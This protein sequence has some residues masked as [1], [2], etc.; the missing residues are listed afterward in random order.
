M[1]IQFSSYDT[2]N[3]ENVLNTTDIYI[4]LIDISTEKI[5]KI[6][7]ETYGSLKKSTIKS[8]KSSKRCYTCKPRGKV[9]KHIICNS[10]CGHFVFH[11]DMNHR[12]LI[13][14]T[15]IQHINT[16]YELN[17]QQLSLLFNAIN[18]FCKFWNINDYQ[19]SFHC[20]SWQTHEHLHIKMK[21]DKRIIERMRGDHFRK[22]K[23]DERYK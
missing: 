17:E 13:I 10:T 16:I 19:I 8:V 18:T 3:D 1:S 21:I 4:P 14:I 15:P 7:E 9:K 5:D 6:I 22:I 2:T 11:H 20:G 12:P 23:Y